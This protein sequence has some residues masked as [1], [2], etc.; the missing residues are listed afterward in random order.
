MPLQELFSKLKDKRAKAGQPVIFTYDEIPEKLKNQVVHIWKDAIG[1]YGDY[2]AGKQVWDTLHDFVSR[3]LGIPSLGSSRNPAENC[4]EFLYNQDTDQ[5]LDII[6]ASFNATEHYFGK[7][8]GEPA[9]MN[10]QIGLSYPPDFA[11]RELN[12]RFLENGIGYQYENGQIIRVDSQYTYSEVILPALQL[13]NDAQFKPALNEFMKSHE[14][15]RKGR[16]ED[17]LSE[18]LKAF[19]SVMKI[20]IAANEWVVDSDASAAKLIQVCFDNGLLPSSLISHFSGLRTTLESGLPTVR[21]KFA[22]HGDGIKVVEVPEYLAQ[23]AINLAA[24]NIVLLVNAYKSKRKA[25]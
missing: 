15:Y 21:N 3:E 7:Y 19:E 6:Q 18:A 5:V 23:Y 17:T 8:S 2:S 13:L 22:G 9:W 20:I 16:Y 1:P 25:S 10:R 24:S 4:L 14:H 12:K 11:I